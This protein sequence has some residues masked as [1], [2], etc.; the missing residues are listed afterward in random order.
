MISSQMDTLEQNILKEF[1]NLLLYNVYEPSQKP[2]IILE[3]YNTNINLLYEKL[4]SYLFE[5][6]NEDCVYINKFV[7][8]HV[9]HIDSNMRKKELTMRDIF[10]LKDI[11][12]I[13]DIKDNKKMVVDNNLII[14][15]KSGGSGDL[16]LH[17]V[18]KNVH[19]AYK[20]LYSEVDK[21][22]EKTKEIVNNFYMTLLPEI[23]EYFSKIY[24][25]TE[26]ISDVSIVN[27]PNK[28]SMGQSL[29]T[30][31]IP[32][33]KTSYPAQNPLGISLTKQR[34]GLCRIHL[35][36]EWIVD[37]IPLEIFCEKK[38][39]VNDNQVCVDV[40]FNNILYLYYLINEQN[41]YFRHY[42]LHP[43][44]ILVNLKTMQIKIIDLG[45]TLLFKCQDE[46]VCESSFTSTNMKNIFKAHIR[47][48]S[49]VLQKCEDVS[50]AKYIMKTITD[51]ITH[52]NYINEDLIFL[53]KDYLFIFQKLNSESLTRYKIT[54][55]IINNNLMNLIK[56]KKF[57]DISY[58]F[59]QFCEYYERINRNFETSL[60]EYKYNI[61]NVYIMDIDNMKINDMERKI[62]SN[63]E[64][65]FRIILMRYI[66]IR[67]IPLLLLCDVYDK[68][69]PILTNP[70]EEQKT[71]N[72]N[73]MK[74]KQ[75]LNITSIRDFKTYENV[76]NKISEDKIKFMEYKMDD[77]VKNNYIS[78]MKQSIN[79]LINLIKNNMPYKL[80][81][82]IGGFNDKKKQYL[83]LKNL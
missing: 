79:Y 78:T 61:H 59:E 66:N 75:V 39:L 49:L 72:N 2:N 7:S 83:Q 12:Y 24:Y 48:G 74:I 21:K 52:G 82:F 80:S 27:K 57:N 58:Y 28:K 51:N 55:T 56:S 70:N 20:I 35:M 10:D 16:L 23:G 54:E 29:T 34:T 19:Y 9:T 77:N 44:N 13:I 30:Q 47:K 32:L 36:S 8:E 25:I 38:E 26:T 4:K 43:D 1:N 3:K 45:L 62:I 41:I 68:R 60:Q 15:N 6:R 81:P 73:Y 69:Y 53:L 63:N 67:L 71:F 22:V 46:T 17:I 33:I 64:H 42:D 31:Q 18:Y 76:Y 37:Y 65:L 14:S 11:K 40:I 50:K 5:K